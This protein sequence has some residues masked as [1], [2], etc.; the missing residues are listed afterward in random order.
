MDERSDKMQV[1][2]YTPQFQLTGDLTI[3]TGV[4]LTDY[5]N[6]AKSFISL[7]DVKAWDREGRL[8]FDTAFLNVRRDSI[9]LIVP[10]NQL[11]DQLVD[12]AN[13]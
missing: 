9:E 1:R 4:R 6:E 13:D 7:T 2:V 5:M 11:V 10:V 8:L 3:Y 12:Q